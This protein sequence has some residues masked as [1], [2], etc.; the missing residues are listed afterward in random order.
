MAA[1]TELLVEPGQAVTYQE[2]TYIISRILGLSLV[3]LEDI[4]SGK[5]LRADIKDL[6]IATG[7]SN[8]ISQENYGRE[9]IDL[10]DEEWNEAIRRHRIIR[11]VLAE[12]GNGEL[13]KQIAKQE[14]TNLAT[15]YRWINR[16]K[17][18]GTISSL[19]PLRKAGGRGQSRLTPEVDALLKTVIEKEYLTSQKKPVKKIC[20]E[21]TQRCRQANIT[22]PHYLTIWR[23]INSIPEY[24]RVRGRLGKEIADA[25]FEPHQGSLPTPVSP[26]STVEIDH[27][28]LDI[29]LV[30]EVHRLAIGRPW[31][32]LAI[33]DYSRVV[34]GF[35]ISFDP[36]GALSVGMCLAHALLPKEVWLS[37]MDVKGEWNCWGKMQTIQADNANEFRGDSLKRIC[38]EYGMNL[39]WRPVKKPNW[40]GHIER[41]LGT[42]LKEIHT[43]PGTTFSNP[44]DK[45][46]YDSVGKASLTLYELEK[47]LTTYIVNV[48]H[49]RFHQGIGKSPIQKYQEGILGDGTQPGLGIPRRLLNERKVQLDFLPHVERS[50]QEY[51]V[52][53]DHI[54]YYHHIL[55][56]WVHSLELKS[57]KNRTK[58]KFIFK[59]DPRNISLVYFYDPE[60]KQYYEIPYRDTS[61]PPVTIWEFREARRKLE[62]EHREQIDENMIFEAYAEMKRIEEQ[63]ITKMQQTRKRRRS[64]KVTHSM[65]KSVIGA[66]VD[67]LKGSQKFI[68]PDDE[69]I[70]MPK[71]HKSTIIQPFDELEDG[72]FT[73]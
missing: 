18:T 71:E 47:W 54:H 24:L 1:L 39:Q 20:L 15:L 69:G 26:L 55:K 31:I 8:Q 65:Q 50:V 16:F 56:K 48:Y 2:H 7:I 64:A 62:A 70:E 49:Q 9:M 37:K 41:L 53:I 51:G 30:D 27:T 5:S 43:L 68:I 73:S 40:G 57:A 58:R 4:A 61:R 34:L 42:V 21:V 35:Y 45:G 25:K 60:L 22:P 33:D 17:Q 38:T 36:P 59:R 13:I 10:S 29:V 19:V 46:N 14:K 66:Q 12:Q 72:A 23:R 11:Q 44:R 28:R 67:T 6:R 52:V 3:L 63:A 32:T